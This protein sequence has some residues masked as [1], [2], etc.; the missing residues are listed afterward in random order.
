M[1]EYI[2]LF[3][4]FKIHFRFRPVFTK[5]EIVCNG[6][7]IFYY[8]VYSRSVSVTGKLLEI[9]YMYIGQITEFNIFPIAVG[10]V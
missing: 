10:K 9:Y 5:R 3:L 7:I 4:L 1:I 8:L 6:C 2:Y